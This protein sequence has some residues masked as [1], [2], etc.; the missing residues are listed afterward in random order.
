MA[1]VRLHLVRHG[2]A[3]SGFDGHHDPGLSDLGREQAEAVAASLAPIGPLALV[4]SPLQR[5]RETAAPLERL[6]ASPAVVE[7][8][9]AEIPSPTDD[10]EERTAWLRGAMRGTWSDLDSTYAAWRDELLSCVRSFDRDTVVVT[11]F[12]A[13]NAIVGHAQDDDRV[14]SF[15]PANCSV[16]VV[17]CD[18]DDI[19]LVE[20]GG[21]ASTV[22]R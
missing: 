19:R 2:E 5:T 18:G 11:H 1:P 8:R 3:A 14:V 9:V 10:L 13:I 17:S 6:W 20:L 16:T 7:Q 21:Q 22:V 12:I 15:A 4:T